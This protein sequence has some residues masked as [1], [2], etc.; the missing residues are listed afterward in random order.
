LKVTATLKYNYDMIFNTL[1]DIRRLSESMN[2]TE[3]D[4][5]NIAATAIRNFNRINKL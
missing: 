5:N 2:Y 4:I 3:R 1:K